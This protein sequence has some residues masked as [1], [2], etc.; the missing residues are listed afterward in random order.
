MIIPTS[1][2]R[3]LQSL[4]PHRVRIAL[5]LTGMAITASTEPTLVWMLKVLLDRGFAKPPTIPFW[6]VPVCVIG[7][8]MVRGV[9]TFMTTYLITWVSTRLLNEMRRKMFERLLDVPLGFYNSTSVGQVINSMMFEAQQ[10]ID[11]IKNVLVNAIRSSLTAIGLIG[12][13]FYLNWKLTLVTVV[14]IPTI[15]V[16]VR[17]TGKRLSVLTQRYLAINA[18]MTQVLEETTRAHQVIKLF[19]GQ[20]YERARFEQRADNLRSYSIKMASTFAATVPITQ[21]LT[22]VAVSVVI[23]I[24][25]IQATQGQQTTG[26]FVAFITNMLM[27]L[28]PLK[29]LAE[30]NGPLQRGL[31][32]SSAVFALVD[33]PVERT[34]GKT[35]SQRAKGRIDFV[36]VG[37]TYPGAE[38]PAL[39]NINLTIMPGE[40][41][42]FVGMSGG[43]KSTLVNL[44]PE[45]QAAGSGEIQLDGEAISALA[46]P[47]LR[48]Q[49]A[50]VSQHVVLFDDTVAANIAYGDTKPDPAR[51]EAAAKAAHLTEV[52]AGL[53]QGLQTQVGDN[54]NRLSG[55]QRQRLAIAR[56]I[57]KDAPIL[58]LDE[59]TSALDSES[60]RSVQ[61]ELDTLMKGRTTLVIAHRL[62]TIE[63]ASR[64]V[65]L[66]HG[67][68]VEVGSHAELLEAGGAYASLYHS[69]FEKE[70]AA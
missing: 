9:S 16:I 37:F 18:E 32:A 25:L 70:V 39:E 46:L 57:Y 22:A 26:E 7:L 29:Q 62:S 31:S 10:V 55:G 24:A 19:G 2:R 12:Y 65:V 66:V 38:R 33:A 17:I 44:V 42:A 58:I 53:P 45:F 35:L 51:I 61:A 41:V 67:R 14:L 49:M 59:A 60:E 13:L 50:M 40:T 69:Q 11:M 56:A 27:I 43:G 28:A 8:F 34:D 15:S 68:I 36:N 6:T 3:L 20:N 54:G 47:S 4:K 21:T 30:V 64:I 1:L 63:R 52:I 5:A 48:A 23:V